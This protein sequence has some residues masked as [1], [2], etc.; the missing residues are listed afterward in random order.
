MI[1]RIAIVNRGEAAMR[2]IHAVRDLNAAAGRRAGGASRR[3]P[4]TPRASG[5]RCS[6]AR[7]TTPTTSAP[8]RPAPTSTTRSSSAPCARPVR[9]PRG[10]AGASSPRTPPS[11][12]CA[13]GSASPSSARAPRRCA[14]SA[15]RSAASSSPRRSACRS[16]RGAAA[17]STPSR[18]RRPRPRAS[19][20]PS[21]SRPR[22]AAAGAASAASTP[23]PTSPT[24]TSA[25]ATRRSGPSAPASS[26]S[27]SS[28]PAPGTSRCRSSPTA[29]ARRGPS[30]CATARCS[31]ATRRSSRSPP[32]PCSAREQEQEVRTSAERLAIAVGYAGAGTVEFLYHPGEKFFAFLEVNTRLQVEHP[33]TEVVTDT[34]LVKLQIHVADGGRLDDLPDGRPTERGHAVEARL[35][36]EDPDRDFAPS[37]GRIELLDLPVRP[38]HPRRHRGGRGRLDPRRLRLD[39]R[40]D[41]RPRP[42]PRRG[43][44]PPAPRALPRRPSSSTAA[45]PT[46]A[47][48]STCSTSPR[49]STASAD[50]GWI[51]RVR[52]EGR[53][54]SAPA[55]R[56]RPRRRRHRG[57][58]GRRGHR[59]RPPLRVGAGW[60]SPGAARRWAAPSTSSCAARHTRSWCCARR[61][62]RYRVSIQN[63][64]E[65][66]VVDASLDRIDDHAGRITVEGRTH[67]LITATHGPV[68]LVEVDGITHRVSRD[69]GGVVRSPAPAL[70]V[71]TPVEVGA[72]VAAGAP[73]LVLESMKMETVLPSPF[74]ARVREL[75]V[76][77][78][79]QVETGAP[80][81]RLEPTG[82]E[83]EAAGTARRRRRDGRPRPARPATRHDGDGVGA[84]RP[85]HRR[86]LRG[87][88][89]LRRRPA[90][91]RRLALPPTSPR[92]TRLAAAGQVPDRGR[93]LRPRARRRL[94]RAE[95][96]PAGRRGAAHRAAR[97][98]P[99]GALPHLPA[100][101]RR[102][103]GRPPRRASAT[104]SPACCAT[105]AS[106]TSSAR[107]SS[108]RPSSAS[109]SPSSAPPPRSSSPPRS[110]SAGSAS[111]RRGAQDGAAAR[112]AARPARRRHPAA[113]PGRRRP[114]PQRPLPLV[115][116]AARRRRTGRASSPG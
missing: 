29:R 108:R 73:V 75:L 68:H 96:Q 46:R 58:R 3:S 64:G 63:G 36:A 107:R 111:P 76:A 86:P 28:S 31:A 92:G 114:R 7:A 104:S 49:S 77:V 72:E 30:A 112:D 42:R 8:R 32:R 60:P 26:S 34:D 50:T 21:C 110:C 95:P 37:P 71:A 54:V 79:S 90:D 59:A 88:A 10:S 69:E 14:S 78:G 55:L 4:C 94:R 11:P 40:Q 20:T 62:H 22:P 102:R 45:R 105:T 89:R 19:A 33:I 39:D 47:S 43:A 13:S 51:D 103:P 5:G 66:H 85:R 44:R 2:L 113:L 48:S 87:G 53:L 17:A 106:P 81:V 25:P 1:S 116:P 109:S 9:T 99:Q 67:R 98:Q 18:T 27:R 97:A 91:E 16:R 100:E 80:L 93:D 83:D 38:R 84:R 6:C 23:T 12:S 65:A 56:H 74:A 24:P 115:R 70:V 82:D 101:P 35:N 41:H 52:A 15:T 61:P 57:L